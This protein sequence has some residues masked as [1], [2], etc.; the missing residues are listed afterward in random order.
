MTVAET[1]WWKERDGSPNIKNGVSEDMEEAILALAVEQ[2]ALGQVR[3]ANEL[4]KQ[5]EHISAAGVRCVWLWHNLQTFKQRLKAL[6]EEV[7]K[8][9]S[10]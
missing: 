4:L 9:A 3:V 10:S 2:P 7:A 1:S 8:K 5:G 6:E